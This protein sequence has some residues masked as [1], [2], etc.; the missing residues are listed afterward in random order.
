M[1]QTLFDK[2][3]DAHVVLAQTNDAPPVLYID[4]HLVHEVTSPQAFAELDRRG[5]KLR[6]PERTVATIDHSIPTWPADLMGQR[7][8]ATEAAWNQ[9]ERFEENCARHGVELH[10]WESPGRGIVH[11]IGPEMGLTQPGMTIVCGDS[12]TATHGAFGALAFGI[13]T[14]EVGHVMATQCLIQSRPKSMRVTVDGPLPSGVT[15]K[16][17]V[18]QI[19]ARLGTGGATGHVIEFAGTA[20]EALDMEGR[21]TICNMAIE[22]GA[23]A[24]MIAPDQTTIEWLRGR[25][26]CPQGDAFE[27]EAERWL[28]LASDPGARYDREVSIDA[29]EIAPTV[30]WGTSPDMAVAI[31]QPVPIPR[32]DSA[33]RALEYMQITPGKS[34]IGHP[35][36]VVFIGSCTNSRLGDLR[37]AAEPL[38]GKHVS[39][40]VRMLVVPGSETIRRQAEAEGL[41]RVFLA[42]G[43]EWRESGCS[44]CI[45]M[46]GDQVEP[47]QTAI[48]TS[49]RNF[50]GRQGRG[51]RSLLA[52]PA[53][54]AASAVAGCVTDPRPARKEPQAEQ[55]QHPGVPSPRHLGVRI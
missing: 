47:G 42:A 14:T 4:L 16:D 32:D 53:T 38:R 13:G 27:A 23:R 52:S 37:A 9:V 24:G 29:R 28:A 17:L 54:A 1:S 10:G 21:M 25:P 48:S 34:L 22:A 6:C 30:T 35:I 8:Y 50:E 39:P 12:H 46:N 2:V 55:W 33:R 31:D 40:G 43:A 7:R 45:A 36:D 44:M 11:V 15:A 3:W 26:A 5:L 49:N 19:I 20:I 18:L 51:S 41:D